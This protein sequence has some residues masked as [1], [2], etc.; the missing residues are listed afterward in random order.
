MCS[1]DLD[2]RKDVYGRQEREVCSRHEK[3]NVYGRHERDVY[4]SQK[5]AA[6]NVYDRQK[7]G[8]L[9]QPKVAAIN[10]FRAR[11]NMLPLSF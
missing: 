6:I 3:R 7:Y 2:T 4:G 9:R 10:V 11:E 1:S 8:Q 5:V